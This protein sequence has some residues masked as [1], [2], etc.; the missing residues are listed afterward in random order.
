MKIYGISDTHTLHSNIK[1]PECDVLIH[2]GDYSSTGRIQEITSFLEWFSKQPA[3]F[4]IFISGNHDSLSWD[5]RSLFNTL[6]KDYENDNV[7][8]LEDSGIE[9]KGLKIYG[10][11][12]TPTFGMWSYM[13][14]PYSPRMQRYRD[15]IPDNLD[16]LISHGPPHGVCSMTSRGVDAGCYQLK[17]AIERA[18]P[19][20]VVCGH[21]HESHGQGMLG[22]TK[23]YN[24]ANLN[25]YYKFANLATE[26]KL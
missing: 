26:I 15:L 13:V 24:V 12:W 21:L 1:V 20:G 4:K 10:T 9:L 5:N 18:K 23:I 14:D 3:E 16:I 19:K 6:V 22:E 8:Y 7:F 2:A 17:Q 25:E 11:P